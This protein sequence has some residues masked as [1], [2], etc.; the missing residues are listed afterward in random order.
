M[1]NPKAHQWRLSSSCPGRYPCGTD[2]RQRARS[3]R[4]GAR[5][6]GPAAEAG[7]H[8]AAAAEGGRVHASATGIIIAL[9]LGRT[10]KRNSF[11]GGSPH[12][13][14]TGT[15][16]AKA[17]LR[18]HNHGGVSRWRAFTPNATGRLATTARR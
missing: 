16:A 9:I 13:V 2:R 5:I 10:K 3:A 6:Q 11:G 7:R 15:A 12:G 17:V 18:Q 1:A 4:V 14:A 8:G